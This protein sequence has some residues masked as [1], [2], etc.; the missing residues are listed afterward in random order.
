MLTIEIHLAVLPSCVSVSSDSSI[1]IT[2]V[3]MITLPAQSWMFV[4]RFSRGYTACGKGASS[5]IPLMGYICQALLHNSR[6]AYKHSTVK[7]IVLLR[8]VNMR[9]IHFHLWSSFE[10]L[11]TLC[12][13]VYCQL[14]QLKR[15][16]LVLSYL[17]SRKDLQ[18]TCMSTSS[19]NVGISMEKSVTYM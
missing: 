9:T 12:I 2:L 14:S 16:I 7:I 4:P 5:N 18:H 6:P 1:F 17:A 19:F 15:S 13:H 8:Y 10:F 3:V 11:T